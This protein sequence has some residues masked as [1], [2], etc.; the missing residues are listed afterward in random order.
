VAKRRE[1]IYTPG[2]RSDAWLKVKRVQTIEVVVGGWTAGAGARRGL[3]GALLVGAFEQEG[4]TYLGHVGTGFDQ[5][6][7]EEAVSLLR[8]L[9][10]TVCPFRTYPVANARP[11][12]VAP[13]CV[14][15]IRHHGWTHDRK[16]RMGVFVR[17]RSD[18][19]ASEP[20]GT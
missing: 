18:V 10:T 3:P 4:L 14:C 5:R 16:L 7:L 9:E 19:P 15:E 17:W 13:R 12:W 2:R 20:E 8:P 11:H 6:S 1:G